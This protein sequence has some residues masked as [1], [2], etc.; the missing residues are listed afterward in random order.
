MSIK[1]HIVVYMYIHTNIYFHDEKHVGSQRTK[2]KN[3]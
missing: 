3:K 2:K 1:L